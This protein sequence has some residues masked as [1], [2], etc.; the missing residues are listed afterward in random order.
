MPNFM[1][2]SETLARNQLQSALRTDQQGSQSTRKDDT[3]R[4]ETANYA[5]DKRPEPGELWLLL[6]ESSVSC[7]PTGPGLARFDE[8]TK[9]NLNR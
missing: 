8:R 2:L 9:A 4:C 7:S 1:R 5:K 6:K 3:A